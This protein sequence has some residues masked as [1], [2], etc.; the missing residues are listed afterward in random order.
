LKHLVPA[1]LLFVSIAGFSQTSS[2]FYFDDYMNV[3]QKRDV[4]QAGDDAVFLWCAYRPIGK[5]Y[6]T[7]FLN[8]EIN[9]GR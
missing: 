2:T 5:N 6:H 8:G 1:L 3:V 9:T 7:F 4:P